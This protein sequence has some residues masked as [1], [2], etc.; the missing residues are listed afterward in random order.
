MSSQAVAQSFDVWEK[1]RMALDDVTRRLQRI[2]GALQRQQVPFAFVGGQAVAMWVATVE[3]AAVRTTKDVDL[4]LRREDLSAARAAALSVDMDYF[5]VLG[6]GMFLDRGDPNPR[7]AVHLIWAGEK[8][9]PNNS[10]PSPTLERCETL[11]GDRPI[12]S[13]PDLVL[14][15]LMSNRDQDRVHL[16]DMIDVGLVTRDTLQQ[17]PPDV[18]GNLDLLLSESGR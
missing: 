17:L 12:V 6:V 5:E 7:H 13:L 3:P 9:R 11:P 1:H 2:T 8:V 14:M 18:A 16:R 4:L 10:H 15:K